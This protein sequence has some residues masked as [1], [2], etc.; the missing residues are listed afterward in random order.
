MK[1][2]YILPATFALTLQA[3]LLFGLPGKRPM[4][5]SPP[6]EEGKLEDRLK[7]LV[8]PND[9]VRA[10]EDSES[11]DRTDRTDKTAPRLV[12]IP[13]VDPPPGAVTIPV[14]PAIPGTPGT[15]TIP[16][17]WAVQRADKNPS[18]GVVNWNELDRVPRVRLQPAPVY[19]FAMRQRG[20]EGMVMV[21]FLVDETGNV[22]SPAILSVTTPGFE[23]AAL[24]A[25]AK[26]K[27]E[28]GCKNGRRVRFRMSVPLIFRISGE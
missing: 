14:I 19:P 1:R 2:Q 20:A 10:S 11:S 26:W 13:P 25:V 16:V 15:K 17:G 18:T 21:E 22:Y 28:P 9:P 12:D 23:E 3:F 7:L 27:F 24:R 5:T 6:E 4:I 8:E